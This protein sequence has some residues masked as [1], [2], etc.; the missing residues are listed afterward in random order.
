MTENEI[1][2][3][4]DLSKTGFTRLVNGLLEGLITVFCL[5]AFA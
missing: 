2:K 1:A 3:V 5:C 4:V